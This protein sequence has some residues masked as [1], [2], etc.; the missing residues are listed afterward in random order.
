MNRYR[1]NRFGRFQNQSG[2]PLRRGTDPERAQ[3]LFVRGVITKVYTVDDPDHPFSEYQPSSMY[4][5]V[6]T[7]SSMPN[8]ATRLLRNVLVTRPASSIHSSDIWKPRAAQ[9]DVTGDTFNLENNMSPMNADG[10]HVIVSFLDDSW[11]LPFVAA[12][13]QHPAVDVGQENEDIGHRINLK[14]D[15]GN[16]R[17]VKHQGTFYGID[18]NA[19]FVVDTTQGF[20]GDEHEEKSE[21]PDAPEDGSAGNYSVYLPAG[22]QLKI[23]VDG[24]AMNLYVKEDKI[25]LGA[26]GAGDQ[27]VLES[28]VQDELSKI[29]TELH[30]LRD[31]YE[32]HMHPTT[33]YIPPLIPLPTVAPTTPNP[34]NP[35]GAP[36]TP[37]PAGVNYSPGAT[38]SDIVT[39]DS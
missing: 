37:P 19:D 34:A 22:S 16:P 15:D 12:W 26:D 27:A 7:Y 13:V 35:P 30:K 38:N 2:L 5:E 39:I 24:G 20:E 11:N 9:L 33:D 4:C 28:K 25:E 17:F 14:K 3:G 32:A 1:A 10:D 36:H 8:A 29:Q 21:Q 23:I 31:S 18:D 6:L